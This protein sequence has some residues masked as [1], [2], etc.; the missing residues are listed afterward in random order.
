MHSSVTYLGQSVH[1]WQEVFVFGEHEWIDAHFALLEYS[2][3]MQTK[4]LSRRTGCFHFVSHNLGLGQLLLLGII[5][6]DAHCWKLSWCG[7]L[8]L[9]LSWMTRID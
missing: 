4:S 3:L 1:D 5:V 9:S 6:V 8:I 2:A 7:A